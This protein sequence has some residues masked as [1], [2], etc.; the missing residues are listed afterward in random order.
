MSSPPL[1]ID[2]VIN[3]ILMQLRAGT[4][5]PGQ[6]LPS[7][8]DE[9]QRF[10]VG[11]NTIVEAYLRLVG[12]GILQAKPGSGYYVVRVPASADKDRSAPLAAATDRVSLLAEQLDRRLPIRPGDGRPP[13]EWLET[14]ELRRYLAYQRFQ[15]GDSYNSSWGHA[16][17]RER[18]RG[19]LAERGIACGSDQLLMTHG[20]NH[21]MDLVIRRYV[22]PGDTVLVDD[23]GYYPLLAKLALAGANAVGVARRHDGPD[24]ADLEAK[25]RKNGARLFFTQS[26]AHNPTGGSITLGTAYSVLRIATECGLLVVEDDPFADILPYTAP[27]LAALD[28]LDRVIY[29]GTFSKTL[30]GSLRTGY[31]AAS[32]M[33]AAEL[34]ELKVITTV[35]TSAHDERLIYQLIEHGHY[36]KHLRRLRARASKATAESVKALEGCGFEI[37]RPIGGGF[38]LWI[39]LPEHMGDESLIHDAADRGIFIAPAANFSTAKH[40]KPAMRVNVAY[41]SD[42]AFLAWLGEKAR[43]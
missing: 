9:A 7:I 15:E 25:A 32:P 10:G 1:K 27:R 21:A 8:R 37:N 5:R 38:Y 33:L 31:L 6:R 12:Q 42:P 22:A 30:A 20:A 4:L 41:G 36:L 19:A 3:S 39:E 34:N 2:F 43:R 29:I 23:P 26:L 28:Q 14:S 11:K 24:I 40:P 18:L 17:L 35:S 13:S 16:P